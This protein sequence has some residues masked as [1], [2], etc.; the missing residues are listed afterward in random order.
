[1][2]FPE[3]LRAW[4]DNGNTRV[5]SSNI[6]TD[7]T[8]NNVRY[9]FPYYPWAHLNLHR[10]FWYTIEKAFQHSFSKCQENCW[11]CDECT[12][13]S[14][15]NLI[16]KTQGIN[17]TT[18]INILYILYSREWISLWKFEQYATNLRLSTFD[19]EDLEICLGIT[20]SCT[21]CLKFPKKTP[22]SCVHQENCSPPEDSNSS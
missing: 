8:V 15:L 14:S 20:N 22:V 3:C 6:F 16:R 12:D 21:K 1:M 13:K 2:T 4:I 19:D 7:I 11:N 10:S 9:L 17:S 18:I 5:C